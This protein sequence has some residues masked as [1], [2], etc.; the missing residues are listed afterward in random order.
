MLHMI[1]WKTGGILNGEENVEKY[2]QCFNM[3]ESKETR[4][5][6]F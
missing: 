1:K 4:Q 2:R 5:L 6:T 3:L